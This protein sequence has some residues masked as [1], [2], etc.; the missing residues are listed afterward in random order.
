MNIEIWTSFVVLRPDHELQL[1]HIAPVIRPVGL[2]YTV[3][4]HRRVLILIALASRPIWNLY[5]VAA[6]DE[7]CAGEIAV[8]E[9]L[10]PRS[11][12]LY[13]CIKPLC[14]ICQFGRDFV[15]AGNRILV[16]QLQAIVFFFSLNWITE[17]RRVSRS[18]HVGHLCDL[19]DDAVW[20]EQ[21]TF[22][23]DGFYCAAACRAQVS[24]LGSATS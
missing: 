4:R 9:W 18:R 10:L 17:R 8:R 16:T 24:Q 21:S 11:S 5:F 13:T 23:A 19:E 20:P 14:P 3:L 7:F 15:P 2:S 1:R 22:P 12:R 6:F